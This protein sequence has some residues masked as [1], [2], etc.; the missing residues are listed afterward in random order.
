M[1]SSEDQLNFANRTTNS[2]FH[3]RLLATQKASHEQQLE[4]S[5]FNE[6]A[7]ENDEEEMR[8]KVAILQQQVER[9]EGYVADLE[10]KLKDR[11]ER[12]QKEAN[13]TNMTPEQRAQYVME[14]EERD[15]SDIPDLDVI[16]EYMLLLGSSTTTDTNDLSQADFLK[17]DA[18]LREE[19]ISDPDV[20]RQTDYSFVKF[21]RAK[22]ILET[23]TDSL[24]DIRHCELSGSSFSQEFTV[25]FDVLEATMTMCNLNFEVGIRMKMDIGPLLQKIKDTC[26]ILGFFQVLV[27]YARL[28]DQRRVLFEKLKRSFENTDITVEAL[29]D[30]RLQF[31]GKREDSMALVLNWK[32]VMHNMNRDSLDANI[33][34]HVQLQ[35]NMDAIT[36]SS[37]IV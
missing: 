18:Q 36:P 25:S 32:I 27:H 28:T 19:A 30:S 7:V 23:R 24:D 15:I 8:K 6:F 1:S 3:K 12:R 20:V 37:C 21:T 13:L 10:E 9:M 29:S 35:L 2:E 34:D 4:D 22:N 11:K 14:E 33:R 16:F 26:N 17:P 5:L 31:Q